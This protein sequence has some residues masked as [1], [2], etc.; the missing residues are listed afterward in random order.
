MVVA[1]LFMGSW[2]ELKRTSGVFITATL[3]LFR[4][5]YYKPLEGFFRCLTPVTWHLNQCL[6]SISSTLYARIFHTNFVWAPL[7]TYM[8]LR[9]AT[10]TTFLWKLRAYNVDEIGSSTMLT[11]FLFFIFLSE[12]V[13]LFSYQQFDYVFNFLSCYS[14]KKKWV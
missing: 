11:Q 8:Q 3:V 5:Q 12:I 7:S 10:E 2:K 9:K 6:P 4:G 13:H 1:S 14:K